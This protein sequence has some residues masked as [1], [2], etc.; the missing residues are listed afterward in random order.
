MRERVIARRY[1]KALIEIGH[2]ENRIEEIHQELVK[3]HAMFQTYPEFWKAVSLPI[4]PAESR[5]N[6]LKEVLSEAGF[7]K[8]VIRFFEI[9]VE[10]DR[11]G[12]L[13]TIF[14]IYQELSDKVQ[15]R[16]RGILYAPEPLDDK[17]FERI[18]E[19]LS[20][21]LGKELI[22]EKDIDSL[23]IGGIKAQIGGVVIDG[24]VR[25]Q[26]NRYREKLLTA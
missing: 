15:N 7:S 11:I 18:K 14:L 6:V 1:A 9:L 25:G 12:M 4:Y 17:D 5:K 13:T 24:S 10:K 19:A 23:L 26:L 22:L 2:K 21:Y 16:V 20:K 8:S 3:I